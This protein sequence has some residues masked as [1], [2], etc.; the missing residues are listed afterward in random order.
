[1]ALSFG[2]YWFFERVFLTIQYK[3]QCDFFYTKQACK[4]VWQSHLVLIERQVYDYISAHLWKYEKLS[5]LFRLGLPSMG[6]LCF[7]NIEFGWLFYYRKQLLS[8]RKCLI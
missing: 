6:P 3:L 5:L 1:M 4:A 7:F 2:D 8:Q